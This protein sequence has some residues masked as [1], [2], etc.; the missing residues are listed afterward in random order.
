MRAAPWIYKDAPEDHWARTVDFTP[1]CSIGQSSALC[2]EVPY[3]CELPDL[4][5]NFIYFKE[6]EGQF[7]LVE[8]SS[9]CKSVTASI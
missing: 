7:I 5:K 2:L 6:N 9:Y 8:G 3:S 4:R 1:Q